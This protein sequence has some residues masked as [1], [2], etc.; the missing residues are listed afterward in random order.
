[1]SLSRRARRYWKKQIKK[2]EENEKILKSIW[3]QQLYFNY[4][5][6]KYL[7]DQTLFELD[8]RH[9]KEI[10][11]LLGPMDKTMKK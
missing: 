10:E 4:K 8:K 6:A 11:R 3:F 7:H 5:K 1:M 9:D 2:E